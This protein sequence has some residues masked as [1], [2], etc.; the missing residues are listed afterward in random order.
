[1]AHPSQTNVPAQNHERRK[2]LTDHGAEVWT[3]LGAGCETVAHSASVGLPQSGP[4]GEPVDPAPRHDWQA[5]EPFDGCLGRIW[6]SEPPVDRV[7]DGLSAKLDAPRLAALGNAVVPQI[8][9]L[10]GRAI[11]QAMEPAPC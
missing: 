2:S 11:L 6:Q 8:P 5:A 10:I 9:E 4:H 7:V 3:I 1:V